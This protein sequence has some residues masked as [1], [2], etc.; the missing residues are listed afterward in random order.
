MTLPGM[1]PFSSSAIFRTSNRV[2]RRGQ[3][4]VLLHKGAVVQGR[5]WPAK[6]GSQYPISCI[7]FERDAI[8][9]S[10]NSTMDHQLEWE[11][12]EMK[13]EEEYLIPTKGSRDQISFSALWTSSYTTGTS[14]FLIE[15]FDPLKSNDS[16]RSLTASQLGLTCSCPRNGPNPVT[17][18]NL[19]AILEWT[20]LDRGW[21]GS[22]KWCWLGNR[23]TKRNTGLEWTWNR[24]LFSTLIRDYKEHSRP[25]IPRSSWP[26]GAG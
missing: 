7:R 19:L 17:I 15:N 23:K 24:N 26:P 6:S 5:H 11:E 14:I 25:S 16:G 10:I 13:N 1:T 21:M 22:V 3:S 9:F 2:S 12:C 20:E 18:I 4:E 8:D